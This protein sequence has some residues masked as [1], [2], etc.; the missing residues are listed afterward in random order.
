MR[1]PYHKN[2]RTA[3]QFPRWSPDGATCLPLKG[4][5]LDSR[6]T[7]ITVMELLSLP[8]SQSTPN[9]DAVYLLSNQGYGIKGIGEGPRKRGVDCRQ[10]CS[11]KQ[12]QPV[13]IDIF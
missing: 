10:P 11:N 2:Q 7:R 12:I 1:K 9:T 13:L 5:F 4:A 8:T 6:V 3:D